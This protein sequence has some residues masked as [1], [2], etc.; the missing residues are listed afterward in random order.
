MSETIDQ[1]LLN[2]LEQTPGVPR[3]ERQA[4][5][6]KELMAVHTLRNLAAHEDTVM[7]Q[8]GPS[9]ND[10]TSKL[11]QAAVSALAEREKK[12]C[13]ALRNTLVEIVDVAEARRTAECLTVSTDLNVLY[14]ALDAHCVMS[15]RVMGDGSRQPAQ[16]LRGVDDIINE[17][18]E[19]QETV[20][21]L[22][23]DLSTSPVRSHNSN[24][25]VAQ[26]ITV[27]GVSPVQSWLVQCDV[28]LEVGTQVTYYADADCTK[29]LFDLRSSLLFSADGAKVERISRELLPRG[30]HHLGDLLRCLHFG[31]FQA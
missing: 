5:L 29:A 3:R 6:L 1:I 15:L 20:L 24:H 10:D 9:S 23:V 31:C 18:S 2:W 26:S 25:A 8:M 16:L 13:G 4:L 30:G 17:L 11:D 19:F 12:L 27:R 21:L 7:D 28:E 22:R 14:G